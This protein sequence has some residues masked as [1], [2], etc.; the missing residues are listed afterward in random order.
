M[1]HIV[2]WSQGRLQGKQKCGLQY[3]KMAIFCTCGSNNWETAE[4]RWVHSARGLASTELSFHSCNVLCDCHRSVSRGNK[5]VVKIEIFGLTHWLK[6]RITRKLLKIVY[7]A[8][9]LASIEL[10]FHPCNILRDNRRGVSR[11]NKNVGCGT[12]KRRFFCTCGSNNWETVQDRWVHAARGLT[13]TDATELSF[14]S[15][16]VSRDCR[17]GVHRT[18]KKWRPG[19]VKTTIFCNFGSNNWETVVDSWYTKCAVYSECEGLRTSNLVDG[20]YLDLRKW[21]Y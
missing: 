16:N 3:V 13:S 19:Y 8:T 11:V 18:N 21:P 7:A 4:D 1:Q 17:R 5:N 10:S 20:R 6:H 2:W 15:C 12:W 14:D 9:G